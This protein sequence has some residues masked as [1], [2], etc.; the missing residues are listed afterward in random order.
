MFRIL[1]YRLL[2][3]RCLVPSL[4]LTFPLLTF[5]EGISKFE[6]AKGPLELS[7]PVQPW[8]FIN[9]VGEK[10]GAWGFENG[11]LEGWVYPLKLFHDFRFEFKLENSPRVYQG[12][13]IARSVRVRPQC[14]QI[15]YS[16]EEFTVIETIFTPRQTPGFVVLLQVDAPAALHVFVKFKPDLNLMWPA[17]VGGQIAT[18]DPSKKRLVLSEASGRYFALLGSPESVGSTAMGYHSYLTNEN[19]DEEIELRVTPEDAR[20]FFVPIV[21]TGGIRGTY[22]ASAIYDQLLKDAPQLYADSLKH[23]VD[24]D[25]EGPE[26][27]TPDSAVN[28]GLRWSRVALDQLKV[29][30]PYVGCGYVSGYGSSGTGTRPMYAWYFE[31]PTETVWNFLDVGSADSLKQALRLIQEYQRRDGDIPHEIPQSFGTGAIDWFKDYPYAYRHTDVP[32]WYLI[33]M[34]QYFRFTGDQAF[35][36]ESWPSIRKAFLF[37]LTNMNTADGLLRIPATDWGSLETAGAVAEEAAMAGEWIASLKYVQELSRL[38]GDAAL[39]KECQSR[40][41]IASHSI[42]RLFWNPELNYYS[43]GIDEHN[44]PVTNQNS[45]IAYSAWLGSLEED[46]ANEVVKRLATANFL[47]DWGERSRSMDSSLYDPA[48][49]EGGAVW[50]FMTTG[51]MIAAYR[52]HHAIQGYTMWMSM[53]HLGSLGARGYMPEVLSGQFYRLL[54]NGVPHQMFSENRA[55]G[56][57]D[58]LLGL[59]LDVPNH[60]LRLSPSL[61]A[62]WPTVS[63]HNFPYGNGKLNIDLRRSPGELTADV[64]I[65]NASAVQLEYSPALPAGA[66]VTAVFR[67]GQPIPYEVSDYGSDVHSAVKLALTGRTTLEVRFSGGVILDVPSDAP[68]EGGTSNSLRVLDSSYRE[69][70]LQVSVEGLPDKEYE[71]RLLTPWLTKGGT[72]ID[73]IYNQDPWTILSTSAPAADKGHADAAGYVH[74]IIRAGLSDQ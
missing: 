47:S 63:V 61:P 28:E 6:L 34:G 27:V 53:I 8:K 36:R 48:I 39:S 59:D 45:M 74:W 44:R 55:T 10:A 3:F 33:A 43:F 58:G 70:Q 1:I 14:V 71:I 35:L 38:M 20:R 11:T 29:C 72:G 73:R 23:Y 64:S 15:T 18:W 60:V 49:Y 50:P 26:F 17:G 56:L 37:S 7:G 19:P 12:A 32:L 54:D 52:Y 16:A 46:H 57:V 25:S 30:N 41:A 9:A 24:L 65:S 40:I 62:S 68:L 21:A 2:G 5:G 31:E 67:D 69:G 13:Q 22:D 51:P 66:K 4:L 42:E